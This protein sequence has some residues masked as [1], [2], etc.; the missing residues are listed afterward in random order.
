M[1][2]FK[3]KIYLPG[4]IGCQ[5]LHLLIGLEKALKKNISPKNIEISIVKY[6]NSQIDRVFHN[7]E[8]IL[9]YLDFNKEI[10]IKTTSAKPKKKF[11]LDEES[12]KK[13]VFSLSND[14]KKFFRLQ[15]FNY[16]FNVKYRNTFWIR[17][18]DRKF[19]I[20]IFEKY[21]RETY[22]H[23][24]LGVVSNDT[25]VLQ[26][27]SYLFSKKTGGTSLLNFECLLKTKN[28]ISQFSGFSIAPFL[29]SEK[30]QKFFLLDK[31]LHSKNEFPEIEND[32]NFIKTLLIEISKFNKKKS[33][34]IIS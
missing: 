9:N 17:G 6:Q 28:I 16:S 12:A 27:S 29:L 11:K 1:S 15:D 7:A 19:N 13:I 20:K 32:W 5:I 25:K 33:Y 14:Y 30:E 23:K 22:I 4:G 21:A 3:Y 10:K 8:D 24:D 31:N 34:E 26:K 2:F 18:L